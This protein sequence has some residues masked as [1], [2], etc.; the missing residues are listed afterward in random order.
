[1][2]SA[3]M[4]SRIIGTA[5]RTNAIGKGAVACESARLQ[6]LQG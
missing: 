1:M 4:R 6:N 5:E 3:S 2:Q